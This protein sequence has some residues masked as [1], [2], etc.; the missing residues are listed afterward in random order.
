LQRQVLTGKTLRIVTT[1]NSRRFSRRLFLGALFAA[2]LVFCPRSALAQDTRAAEIAAQQAEKSKRLTPNVASRAENV[3]DWF[4]D[5]FLSPNVVYATFSSVYPTGGITPGIAWRRAVGH[6]RFN[7]GGAWSFRNYKGVNTSLR[8]PEL[9]GN[10][11]ELEG[12]ASWVDATQV[13]YYGLGNDTLKDDRANYGLQESGGGGSLTWKPVRWFRL[14][15]GVDYRQ[16]ED[17]E[18]TGT[19]P[20]IET[21]YNDLTAPALFEKTTYMQG[22]AQVAIDWRES[23]GYTRR[24]G[25]YAV[26]F[27]D[28]SDADDRFGFRRYDFEIRQM[29]PILKEH[30]I[31]A[32]RAFAQSTET[33]SGQVIPYHLLPSLGGNDTHRG[34]GDFRFRDNHMLVLNGEYRWTPSRILDMAFF[35]DAGKVASE[36]RDLDLE[37]LKTAYGVG[38]RLHSPT[39]T[40]WRIDLAHG[41]EGFRLHLTGSLSF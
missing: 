26:T 11:M 7:L 19:R 40:V 41:D 38:W 12:H 9:A 25:L 32:F 4:E 15:G 22:I 37:D 23:P 14:G 24:G 10:K 21:V 1:T 28:F 20:S 33:E 16:V 34:Y 17:S 2:F 18:G 27:N 29:F 35:V 5:Y 30:F 36:R 13:P 31:L 39:L 3:V 6:A 8:F